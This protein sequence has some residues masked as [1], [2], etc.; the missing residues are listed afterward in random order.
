MKT[1]QIGT[2]TLYHGDALESLK[3]IPDKSVQRT[4]DIVLD[5]FAGSGT[6][7]AV[8]ISLLNA[9][10]ATLIRERITNEEAFYQPDLIT[11]E[12]DAYAK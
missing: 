3:T 10:Y 1:E 11:S 8:A 5:P 6:T 9:D 12:E 4:G 7:G 2:V